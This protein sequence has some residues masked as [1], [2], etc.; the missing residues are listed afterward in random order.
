[1]HNTMKEFEIVPHT[2]DLQIKAYGKSLENLFKNAL[3]GMFQSIGP[4]TKE[5]SYINDQL[6][7]EKFSVEHKI[8]INAPDVEQ[9]L[10]D[11]LSEALYLSDVNDEA[12]LDVT[13]EKFSSTEL[14]A[15]I[16][17]IKIQGFE[18]VEI[19]AVTYHDLKIEKENNLY[20]TNIVFDI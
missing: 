4:I 6:V 1:M 20:S 5:C 9:L 16:K 19:K 8:E 13:F 11:F 7:C 2:A 14:V 12:Y 10:V 15:T 17:G 3:K 18:V